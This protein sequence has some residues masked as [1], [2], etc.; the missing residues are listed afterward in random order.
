[1]QSKKTAVLVLR[2]LLLV[3]EVELEVEVVEVGVVG[4]KGA[5]YGARFST[6]ISTR[7]YR[8]LPWLLAC[9]EQRVTNS[10]P[11]GCHFL[12]G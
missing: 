4:G 10:I 11:V 5:G 3:V 2:V 12:T 6:V 7:R 9:S 1:M 8:W